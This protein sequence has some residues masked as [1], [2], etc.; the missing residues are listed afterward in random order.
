M[1]AELPLPG[2]LLH[3]LALPHRGVAL[4]V[5]ADLGREHEVAAVDPAAVALRLLLEAVHLVVGDLQRPEAPGRLHP[6]H[7]RLEPGV[8]VLSDRAADV[9]VAHA[10]AVRAAERLVVLDER[11]DALDAPA[12]HRVLAGVDQRH[13]P[14]L[15]TRLVHLHR[16]LLHVE[17]HVGHVQEVVREV[18]LDLEALVAKTDHEVGDAVAR[19]RLHDVPQDRPP[20]DLDQRL[21]PDLGLLRQPGSLAAGQNHCFQ[22]CISFT[23]HEPGT[24]AIPADRPASPAAPENHKNLNDALSPAPARPLSRG[25][26]PADRSAAHQPPAPL[27]A[28]IAPRDRSCRASLPCC[29]AANLLA[30]DRTGRNRNGAPGAGE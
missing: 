8:A 25:K 28:G 26:S 22:D 16:V 30:A 13:R 20:A 7:R 9:D 24:R 2:E 23:P 5:V 12:D 15:G 10:V 1:D 27:G 19:V 3:R 11:Q 18:F 21:R 29:T 6:G 17:R 14:R 4:D